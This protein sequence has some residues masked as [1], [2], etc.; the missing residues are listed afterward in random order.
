[1]S[2]VANNESLP[3]SAAGSSPTKPYTNMSRLQSTL[4]K[5][6]SR[7]LFIFVFALIFKF[8]FVFIIILILILIRTLTFILILIFIDQIPANFYCFDSL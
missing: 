1:M 6:G 3:V 5:E 4:R 2:N 8:A 7:Y